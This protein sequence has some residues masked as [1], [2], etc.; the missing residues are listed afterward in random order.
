MDTSR[1]SAVL[2]AK[3]EAAW[4][5]RVKAAADW[6]AR[7]ESG[8]LRPSLF[9]RAGW[10]MRAILRNGQKQ[11]TTWSAR[12]AAF[13]SHW[14]ESEGRKEASLAWALNDVFRGM[15]WIGGVFKAWV[16]IINCCCHNERTAP[17]RSLV[18][19]HSSWVLSSFG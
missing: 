5:Q 16:S 8:E 14:R 2:A 11:D 7:L 9:K 15:F 6:N 1:E 10:A 19:R 18:I 4:Q 12:Y 17:L 13:Q 3:L